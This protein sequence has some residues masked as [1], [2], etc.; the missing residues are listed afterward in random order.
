MSDPLTDFVLA[1]ATDI[2]TAREASNWYT[3][4]DGNRLHEKVPRDEVL[5]W[6]WWRESERH[7]R[8]LRLI[9][10]N[11]VRLAPGQDGW[12]A[13]RYAVQCLAN[14]YSEHPG[15]DPTWNDA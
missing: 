9:V 5:T 6:R 1:R 3:D 15:F 8:A 7:S 10:A 4:G 11:H 13:S 12:D 14:I 2:D